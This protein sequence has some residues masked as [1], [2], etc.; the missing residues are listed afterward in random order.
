MK[1]LLARRRR[2]S[3]SSLLETAIIVPLLFLLFMGTVELARVTYTYYSL[4]KALY[5][6][7]RYIGTQQNVNFC[8]GSDPS[9]MTAKAFVSQRDSA[10]S[11]GGISGLTPDM[12]SIRTQRYSGSTGGL[13]D[14][15]CSGGAEGCDTAQGSLPPDYVVVAIPEGYPIRLRIP[16]LSNQAVALKPRVMLPFGGT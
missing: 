7:A 13:V 1:Q 12:I 3:G 4:Q 14:C 9:I 8:D 10:E 2:R 11:W 5:F 6:V 16:G 15:D